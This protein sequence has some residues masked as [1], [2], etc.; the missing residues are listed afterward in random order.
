M[1]G[2]ALAISPNANDA[3]FNHPG[4]KNPP[5]PNPPGQSKGPQCLLRGT[6]VRTPSGWRFVEELEVGAELETLDGVMPVRWVGVSRYRVSDKG[7]GAALPIRVARSALAE[8]VP[9]QDLYLSPDHALFLDGVFV[10]VKYLEN[11]TTITRASLTSA[12][13]LDYYH[14][15]LATHQVIFAED[16]PVETLLVYEPAVRE[17]FANFVQYERTYGAADAAM[18]PFAPFVRYGGAF[19]EVKALARLVASSVIDVRDPIQ[20]I[21]DRVAERAHA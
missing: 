10:P 13:T 15:E 5:H 17:R 18:I 11:G 1:A 6:R 7:G 16:L 3:A 14:V 9:S 12:R 2:R 20:V 8:N 4:P 21:Y 19:D